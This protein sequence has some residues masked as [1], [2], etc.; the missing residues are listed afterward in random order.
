M[1]R[2][3][4]LGLDGASYK[5]LTDVTREGKLQNLQK[6]FEMSSIYSLESVYPYVTAPAWASAFSG[7]NPGKHG[8][9]DLLE[10]TDS[11]AALPNYR[12]S[13]FPYLWD[14]LSWAGKKMIV[15]GI[16]FTYPA[17]AINGV[18][19]TGRFVPNLSCYPEQ[20]SKQLNLRGYDY[21]PLTNLSN[22]ERIETII[23]RLRLRVETSVHLLDTQEYDVA[24]FVDSLPDAILHKNYDDKESIF[25][26]FFII[27]EWLNK[28]FHSIKQGDRLMVF[29][30]HGFGEIHTVVNIN[31][32]LIRKGYIKVSRAK[33]LIAHKILRFRQK[34]I[35][36]Q[37]RVKV[38]GWP[39][40]RP[41]PIPV[42][43]PNAKAFAY[44]VE[45]MCWIKV[46]DQTC[47]STLLSELNEFKQLGV[48]KNV[49]LTENLYNGDR[50]HEV[51]AQ[52]LI[53]PED[54]VSMNPEEHN[55]GQIIRKL[56]KRRAGH[57]KT[58]V[59]L[60]TGDKSEEDSLHKASILDVTP[61]VLRMYKLPIPSFIDGK[62]LDIK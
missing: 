46:L 2:L 17:P 33:T 4:I 23:D 31:E 25:K 61:T 49:L 54:G 34:P 36:S 58:G 44:R 22:H 3:I 51:P 16:P 5:L 21:S 59:L 8:V 42:P 55:T 50:K 12:R 62:V 29:S 56:K 19:I 13:S 6:L 37:I 35:T 20:L 14:Y 27:D 9:F 45:A 41:Q 24:I 7:V 40:G 60:I 53:E 26:I 1:S 52:I 11:K 38:P 39:S 57:L 28:I 10:Y 32:W 30:D 18:F 43:P 48:V 15:A 47:I